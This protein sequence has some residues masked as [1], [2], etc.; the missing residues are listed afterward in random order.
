MSQVSE[1]DSSGELA[2]FCSWSWEGRST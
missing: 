2:H 1:G